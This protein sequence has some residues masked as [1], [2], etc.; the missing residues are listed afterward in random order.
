MLLISIGAVVVLLVGGV[1]WLEAV[2]G[3]K[4]RRQ[5]EARRARISAEMARRGWRTEQQEES[6]RTVT[7]VT[8]ITDSVAWRLERRV[9][10]RSP[11]LRHEPP[12]NSRWSARRVHSG[13]EALLAIWPTFGRPDITS[14]GK[15]PQ[16][17]LEL[18]LSPIIRV[19]E[20]DERDAELLAAAQIFTSAD[21]RLHGHYALRTTDAAAMD[22]FLTHG[23]ADALATWAPRF[24]HRRENHLVIAVIT[25]AEVRIQLAGYVEE[26]D[27]IEDVARFGVAMMSALS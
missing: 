5:D 11:R 19:L 2:Q 14:A 12:P 4:L 25:S 23:G 20:L 26:P 9:H 8:G 6:Y 24:V 22:R 15:V 17:A 7:S 27:T 3:P 18:L 13:P 1:V 21:T 16:F 10:R